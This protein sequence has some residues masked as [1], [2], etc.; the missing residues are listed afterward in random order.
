MEETVAA[1]M[2]LGEEGFL[3]A[4]ERRCRRKGR[5]ETLG[6]WRPGH[7]KEG[8]APQDS[9][10]ITTQGSRCWVRSQGGR[11][12]DLGC[13]CAGLGLLGCS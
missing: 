1:A 8:R 11:D 2:R 13:P 5:L 3:A 9:S 12:E 10:G 4:E 6:W 7:G